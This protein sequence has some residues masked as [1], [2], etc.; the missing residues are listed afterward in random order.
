MVLRNSSGFEEQ[1]TMSAAPSII[2]ESD[3]IAAATSAHPPRPKS[4]RPI[5]NIGAGGIVRN[6]LLPAYAKA[7]FPVIAISD[8]AP[9]TAANLA[10]DFNVARFFTS[11]AEAI[12]FAPPDAV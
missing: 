7:G 6:A 9:N 4:P 8:P 12:A 3:L 1:A 5:V 10:R 11:A 2:P